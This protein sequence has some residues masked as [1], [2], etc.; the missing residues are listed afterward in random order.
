MEF[1]LEDLINSIDKRNVNNAIISY[2]KLIKQQLEIPDE[3]RL[4]LFELVCFFNS[5]DAFE[6]IEELPFSRKISLRIFEMNNIWDESGFAE[7]LWTGHF[8]KLDNQNANSAYIL[9]LIRFGAFDKAYNLFKKNFENKKQSINLEAFNSLIRS[10]PFINVL[11]KNLSS[12]DKFLQLINENEY[13]PT[14]DTFNSFLFTLSFSRAERNEIIKLT[15]QLLLDLKTLNLQANLGTYG[16]VLS[17]FY[18]RNN[19]SEKNSNDDIIYKIIDKIEKNPIKL[20]SKDDL[21]FFDEAM[22][23]TAAYLHDV[24]LAKRIFNLFKKH[25]D[26]YLNYYRET[27]V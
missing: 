8:S 25:S 23:I 7:Q 10:L 19:S 9:G 12:I 17:I 20:I 24:D 21:I 3:L 18:S 14:I 11:N 16:Y 15:E 4:K 22:K 26:M 5:K 6:F 27:N 2:K 13:N 1:E